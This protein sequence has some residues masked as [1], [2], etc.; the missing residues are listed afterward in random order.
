[1]L[2]SFTPRLVTMLILIGARPAPCAASIPARTFAT[3]KSTSFIARQELEILAKNLLRHAIHAAEVATVGDA[4]PQVMERPA[5]RVKRIHW[6]KYEAACPRPAASCGPV[7]RIR[8][9]GC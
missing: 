9:A 8:G 5:E 7:S 6:E 3:G 2:D 1:M 4:D